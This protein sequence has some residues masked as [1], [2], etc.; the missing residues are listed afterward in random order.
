MNLLKTLLI[1]SLLLGFGSVIENFFPIPLQL[2]EYFLIAVSLKQFKIRGTSIRY[3]SIILVCIIVSALMTSTSV[4]KYGS[5]F[6]RPL[7]AIAILSVFR[8]DYN[9]I[10]FYFYKNLRLIAWLALINFILVSVASSL[11]LTKTSDSGY[12]VHTIGYI[13]NYIVTT[14]RLG[15]EFTRNQGL[16]WEPGVLELLMNILVFIELFE[17]KS[18][19]KKTIL[20]GIIVL[21]TA[22]TTGYVLLFILFIF[23]YLQRLYSANGLKKRIITIFS[24]V[25]VLLA[26]Y[27]IVKEEINYKFTTGVGS[28]NKRQFDMMMG[29]MIALK[30][31]YFGIGPDKERYMDISNKFQVIV[32]DNI[33]YD[34]RANSNLFVSLFCYYGFPLALL[35]LLALYRQQIFVNRKIYF[36]IIVVGLFSEPVAFVDLYF[37]WIMSGA[38]KSD[39]KTL[40]SG[41]SIKSRPPLPPCENS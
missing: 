19:I 30:H 7:V 11:F 37:V 32:G 28:A 5:F 27:P 12:T 41:H 1:F 34:A 29:T 20:P 26:I 10:K 3:I 38:Y 25:V 21:T 17:Y 40:I 6:V 13:F 31:P 2:F 8:Y 16:F 39:Q 4:T 22:S 35:F 14:E 9:K 23:Y 15:F 18:N 24:A 33:S 36:M